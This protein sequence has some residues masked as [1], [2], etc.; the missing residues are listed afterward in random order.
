MKT[1]CLKSGD[2]I[3]CT[4]TLSYNGT[5]H[6]IQDKIYYIIFKDDSMNLIKITDE[7]KK[8][9]HFILEHVSYDKYYFYCYFK[10]LKQLRKQKLNKLNESN[11]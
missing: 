3:Y 6:F 4:K 7:T 9:W 10:P 8:D 2:K 5:D 1:D 11:L